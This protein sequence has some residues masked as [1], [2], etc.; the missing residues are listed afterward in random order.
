M[1]Q[2]TGK[3]QVQLDRTSRDIFRLN[4]QTITTARAVS[5]Q[6]VCVYEVLPG[7]KFNFKMEQF[8]RVDALPVS[9]F[10]S[11]KNR[12]VAFY[13]KNSQVWKPFDSFKTG[14]P[15]AFGYQNIIPSKKPFFNFVDLAN[16]FF[17]NDQTNLTTL[18]DISS[19]VQDIYDCERLIQD[20]EYDF[21][22]YGYGS[23]SNVTYGYT[24]T[25][26]GKLFYKVLYQLGYRMPSVIDYTAS[27][28]PLLQI[29]Q[30][31]LPLMSYLSIKVNYYVPLKWRSYM[32]VNS[33]SYLV[34]PVPEH[35]QE[36]SSMSS[37]MVSFVSSIVNII[38]Y[39]YYGDDYFTSSFVE[40]FVNPQ[41][42]AVNASMVITEPG[43]QSSDVRVLNNGQGQQVPHVSEFDSENLAFT[44]YIVH[45]LS[46][47]TGQA[48]LSAMTLNDVKAAALAKFGYAPECADMVPYILDKSE[49]EINVIPEVSTA[50]T[51]QYSSG[52]IVS[53]APIGFKAGQAQ[54][55]DKL[56]GDF[57]F[58]TYGTF[59]VINSIMPHY[60]YYQGVRRSLL[61]VTQREEYDKNYVKLGYQAIAKVELSKD[62]QS[63]MNQF[64]FTKKY[65]DYA[66]PNDILGG[67]FIIN[68]VNN[69]LDCFHF[70]RNIKRTAMN[71]EAFALA[72]IGRER[73][74]SASDG[75]QFNRVFVEASTDPI[76]QW[77]LF[78]I[79][80]SRP[81][82]GIMSI[83]EH[84]GEVVETKPLGAALND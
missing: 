8:N 52:E 36:I 78:K 43:Q 17:N 62:I 59:I 23:D 57:K 66:R 21:I 27:L 73:T 2:K 32:F 77:Y 80:A 67:D 71:N 81:I 5:M 56:V 28:D 18:L 16:I 34:D 12:N 31:L 11:F 53:G 19:R 20:H 84:D 37:D 68:T 64:G 33:M 70:G 82:D 1:A 42:R 15:Y 72:D 49:S 24:L 4:S 44:Q 69:G 7:D 65:A 39:T 30:S 35:K 76:Q 79:L 45:A 9:A 41:T 47:V 13:V 75:Q 54:G 22:L 26:I 63:P 61:R 10:C 14:A 25:N 38:R 6:P 48:Q 55:I 50:D 60:F 51:A 46:V 83:G 40:P 29:E 58:P 3:N 74:N